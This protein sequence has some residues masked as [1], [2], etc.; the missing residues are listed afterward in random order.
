MLRVEVTKHDGI[1]GTVFEAG[2]QN[3]TWTAEFST[4]RLRR[5]LVGRGCT[6]REANIHNRFKMAATNQSSTPGPR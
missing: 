3:F 6:G 4:R 5:D 2:I 1:L